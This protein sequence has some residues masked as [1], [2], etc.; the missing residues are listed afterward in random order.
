M[1]VDKSPRFDDTTRAML[2]TAVDQAM[3][4]KPHWQPDDIRTAMLAEIDR[5]VAAALVAAAV[6]RLAADPA[7]R[8]PAR[9]SAPGAWWTGPAPDAAPIRVVDGTQQQC[10]THRGELAHNC[11]GCKADRIAEATEAARAKAAAAPRVAAGPSETQL[12][13]RATAQLAA[14]TAAAA[15]R[16]AVAAQRN[17]ATTPAPVPTLAAVS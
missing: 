17:P 14:R 7:T 5:G 9:L 10:P 15:A 3:T 12:A 11:A 13:A 2:A 1:V 4:L 8:S 16:A 6:V